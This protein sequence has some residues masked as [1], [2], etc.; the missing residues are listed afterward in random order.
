ME[1][2]ECGSRVGLAIK[3]ADE[4]DIRKGDIL[5]SAKIPAI[6]EVNVTLTQS[7]LAKEQITEGK[8]YNIFSGFSSGSCMVVSISG[9]KATLKIDKM[10]QIE[11]GDTIMLGRQNAPRIFAAGKVL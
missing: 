10:M 7:A 9:E 6:T 11:H 1:S 2:A 8:Q 5:S 4:N 3:G